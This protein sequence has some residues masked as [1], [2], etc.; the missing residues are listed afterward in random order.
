MKKLR[1][2]FI[3]GLDPVA[4]GGA[5]GQL[6][7]ASQLFRSPL[8]DLCEL[9]PIS[10][11]QR[12]SPPPPLLV[13]AYFAAGRMLKVLR[14][15]PG[16]DVVLVFASDGPGLVEKGIYCLV[17]RA[18]GKGVVLRTGS[19]R[20]A[21]LSRTVA[22]RWWLRRVFRACHVICSQ[23]T[24]WTKCFEQYREAR[25]KIVVTP[26]GVVVP[27]PS[28]RP[29]HDD[30]LTVSFVGRIEPEKGLSEALDAF[31]QVRRAYPQSQLLLA[32]QGSG[33]S[34]LR[35]KAISLGV[36]DRVHFLGWL[37]RDQVQELLA[38]TDVFI[39]PS[40]FEGMPNA[41]LE[42]M[43]HG[44][45][46]IATPV[47][48]VEDLVE[49]G[50]T[51]RLVPVGD[52]VALAREMRLLLD[53]PRLRAQLGEQGRARVRARYDANITWQPFWEAVQRAAAEAGIQHPNRESM[54]ARLD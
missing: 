22:W 34:N 53:D 38:R 8:G 35:K 41:L 36:E 29:K 6:A 12:R 27:P 43:A 45:A 7:V 18:A 32:G 40:H 24:Y 48:A 4:Q 20:V 17:A 50:K 30:T 25:D 11:T 3:A 16:S 15:L 26:N 51:G 19:G 39:M 44:V 21:D 9:I 42:A 31:Q 14:L 33:E 49:H 23:G 46:V 5:G 47:G 28:V 2:L 13:R 37:L 10:S 52:V 54:A 1:V